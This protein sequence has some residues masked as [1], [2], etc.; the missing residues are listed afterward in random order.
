MDRLDKIL[1]SGGFGS[2]TEIKKILKSGIVS[3]DGAIIKDPSVHVDVAKN[4]ITVDGAP[5]NYREHIYLML[6]KPAG[7]VSATHDNKFKTV[8][9]LVP[10]EYLHFEPFPAGRLDRDTEGLLLLTDDGKLAH[11][12]LSP[13][14]HVQKTYY[15]KIDQPVGQSDIDAFQ[16]G[17]IIEHGYKTKPAQLKIISTGVENYIELTITEGKFHQVKQMFEAVGK[18]VLFLKR[19]S[20]GPLLLD[21]NL[22]L[23]EIR[24]LTNEELESIGIPIL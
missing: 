20:F 9:D 6:N 3:V 14:K 22:K 5:F 11:D 16:E 24:E 13:K 23:G 8:I 21:E 10:Q 15:A 1:A 12:L 2:R 4:I 19:I 18:K 7:V 17:V